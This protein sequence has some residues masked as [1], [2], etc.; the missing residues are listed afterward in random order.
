MKRQSVLTSPEEPLRGLSRIGAYGRG[1]R[2]WPCSRG[3]RQ[4]IGAAERK[5]LKVGEGPSSKLFIGK[6]ELAPIGEYRMRQR[7]RH[8]G[9]ISRR[10]AS[11]QM[12]LPYWRGLL[13][14]EEDMSEK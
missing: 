13:V 4:G 8:G 11:P 12:A 9:L 3:G 2:G 6:L 7:G 10:V 14:K 5:I 1:D